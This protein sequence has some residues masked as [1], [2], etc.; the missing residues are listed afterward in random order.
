M[1]VVDPAKPESVVNDF[2]YSLSTKDIFTNMKVTL[3][4]PDELL[5]IIRYYI[6][7]K[8]ILIILFIYS[9]IKEYS[10]GHNSTNTVNKDVIFYFS[11]YLKYIYFF[12]ILYII[13][14][15]FRIGW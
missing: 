11:Y 2:S 4:L 5:V 13:Y 12:Q 3:N 8:N 7:T 6:L 10:P 15:Y 9:Y 1:N 14:D